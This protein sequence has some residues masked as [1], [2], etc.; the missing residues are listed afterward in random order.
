MA[1]F[2]I[3]AENT[4]TNP[5][6]GKWES[7][8]CGTSFASLCISSVSIQDSVNASEQTRGER[9]ELEVEDAEQDDQGAVTDKET[10]DLIHEAQYQCQQYNKH[11][12]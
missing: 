6:L 10:A 3:N 4:R 7:G 8:M 9:E 2:F 5:R 11:P 12:M 1:I